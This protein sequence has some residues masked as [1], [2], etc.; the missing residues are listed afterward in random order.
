MAIHL[1]KGT[2]RLVRG[3]GLSA[4]HHLMPG[5]SVVVN[6]AQ[7]D[8]SAIDQRSGIPFKITGEP[9][10]QPTATDI[11][12]VTWVGASSTAYSRMVRFAMFGW[13]PNA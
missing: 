8:I 5:C 2:S 12:R 7:F 4:R 10:G 3:R 1:V 9:P 11:P 13:L 6:R